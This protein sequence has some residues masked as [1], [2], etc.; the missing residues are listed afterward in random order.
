[1][2]PGG[3]DINLFISTAVQPQRCQ[4][5]KTQALTQW[6]HNLWLYLF[7]KLHFKFLLSHSYLTE[8]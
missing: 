6:I 8:R 2:C 3:S 1:M 4:N 7:E 5:K